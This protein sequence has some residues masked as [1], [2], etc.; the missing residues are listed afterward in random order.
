MSQA[1][2]TLST[3]RVSKPAG[4][5]AAKRHPAA[6]LNFIDPASITTRFYGMVLAGTCL[7]PE[8]MDGD[9]VIFDREA[10][11]ENG[12]FA[13]FFYRPELAAP[14]HRSVALKRLVFAPRPFV[15]FPWRDHPNS[16][17]TPIIIV[18]Q[19]NPQQ[20]WSVRCADLLA[21]HRCLGR[22]TDA[23]V[24]KLLKAEGWKI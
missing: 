23:A 22:A 21:V 20:Q 18:E 5:A 16:T 13:N 24:K 10:P 1:A 11:L 4:S 8:Y 19:F 14:G 17:V 12:C 9:T 6:D 7:Q 15:T 2:D 3:T